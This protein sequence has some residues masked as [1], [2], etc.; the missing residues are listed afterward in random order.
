MDHTLDFGIIRRSALVSGLR[1]HSIGSIGYA[2]FAPQ[3]WVKKKRKPEQYL[4]D[5]PFA[6][7]VGGEFLARFEAACEKHGLKPKIQFSCTS[8]TQ[9]ARLVETGQAMAVLPEM[10]LVKDSARLDFPWLK[11]YR[12]EIGVAWHPRLLSI[13]PKAVRVLD[14]LQR[15]RSRQSWPKT[16]SRTKKVSARLFDFRAD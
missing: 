16:H 15:I 3:A 9:A 6:V 12:R 5:T 14:G 2:L 10:A 7:S 13:R 1:F 8:F 11:S 4:T